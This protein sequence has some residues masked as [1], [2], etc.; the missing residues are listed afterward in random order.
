MCRSWARGYIRGGAAPSVARV[1]GPAGWWHS[2][3]GPLHA[4]HCCGV[5]EA[6]RPAGLLDRTP[7]RRPGGLALTW[8]N[9]GAP[10]LVHTQP[11]DPPE[12][13]DG[14]CT[15]FMLALGARLTV[16]GRPASGPA[17]PREREGRPCSTCALAVAES[18]TEARERRGTPRGVVVGR[19]SRR[20]RTSPHAEVV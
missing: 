7:P 5:L 13:R 9:I 4:R 11:H 8:Y 15:I 3:C 14:V 6:R 16:N 2:T 1:T 17:W 20:P 12:R 10:L 19:A 18:W